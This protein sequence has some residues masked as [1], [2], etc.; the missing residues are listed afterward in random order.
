MCF[1]LLDLVA[2]DSN[3]L[4]VLTLHQPS[5]CGSFSPVSVR[6][7]E[8]AMRC[9]GCF[10]GPL[11]GAAC[12]SRMLKEFLHA[13]FFNLPLSQLLG[14]NLLSLV[15]RLLCSRGSQIVWMPFQPW[16]HSPVSPCNSQFYCAAQH[17]QCSVLY[18][19]WFMKAFFSRL[20]GLH[21]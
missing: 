4:C 12:S 3:P 9:D 2:V 20:W 17:L 6:T 10:S 14:A 1:S 16:P 7:R 21:R 15:A 8:T 5:S 18:A 11:L 19:V 13:C